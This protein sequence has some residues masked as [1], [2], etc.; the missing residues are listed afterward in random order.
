MV[1]TNRID[2]RQ[3]VLRLSLVVSMIL[4]AMPQFAAFGQDGSMGQPINLE[5][6]FNRASTDDLQSGSPR[7][8]FK[9]KALKKSELVVRNF[10]AE[11][12]TFYG[13][14]TLVALMTTQAEKNV[15][16]FRNDP[17]TLNTMV[18]VFLDPIGQVGFLGFLGASHATSSYFRSWHMLIGRAASEVAN[19]NGKHIPFNLRVANHIRSNKALSSAAAFLIKASPQIGL[20][21]GMMASDFIESYIRGFGADPSVKECA[22]GIREEF[23]KSYEKHYVQA[24]EVA[25]R[26]WVL[27]SHR[28]LDLV[29]DAISLIMG[30]MAN[31]LVIQKVITPGLK[32]AKDFV[33]PPVQG[34][35]AKV[36]LQRL[37]NVVG[38]SER[39]I[40][41]GVQI[42]FGA[43]GKIAS[44]SGNFMVRM[45]GLMVFMGL[46]GKVIEPFIIQK[47]WKSPRAIGRAKKARARFHAKTED[48]KRDKWTNPPGWDLIAREDTTR[49][50]FGVWGAMGIVKDYHLKKQTEAENV[51]HEL[52]IF[53]KR[54][55]EWRTHLMEKTY[56]GYYNWSSLVDQFLSS[57]IGSYQFYSD[58]LDK[59]FASIKDPKVKNPYTTYDPYHGVKGPI[60]ALSELTDQPVFDLKVAPDLPTAGESIA[61]DGSTRGA[62][63][64]KE[65]GPTSPE[66]LEISV[67]REMVI[68]TGHYIED[69]TGKSHFDEDTLKSL[70]SIKDD[71]LR[72]EEFQTEEYDRRAG[73]A[74][75]ELNDLSEKTMMKM[76]EVA[77]DPSDSNEKIQRLNELRQTVENLNQIRSQLGENPQPVVGGVSYLE[78]IQNHKVS[79]IDLPDAQI[80]VFPKWF[81]STYTAQPVDYLVATAVCGP[82]A[83]GWRKNQGEKPGFLEKSSLGLVRFV[84][85]RIVDFDFNL[86]GDHP[87]VAKNIKRA[88]WGISKTSDFLT[89]TQTLSNVLLGDEHR[90]DFKIYQKKYHTPDTGKDY[91]GLLDVLTSRLRVSLGDLYF[92]EKTHL[93]RQEFSRWWE[94]NVQPPIYDSLEIFHKEYAKLIQHELVPVFVNEDLDSSGEVPLG[95]FRSLV[96]ELSDWLGVVRN[97]FEIENQKV[98]DDKIRTE[99][100]K[101]FEKSAHALT[102]FFWSLKEQ[103]GKD[104]QQETNVG[105]DFQSLMGEISTLAMLSGIQ[106][107]AEVTSEDDMKKYD[108]S[109]KDFIVKTSLRSVV[110]LLNEAYNYYYMSTLVPDL[111]SDSTN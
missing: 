4:I 47:Y 49:M 36:G 5:T 69:L 79:G 39:P 73:L 42:V 1:K 97:I 24:C 67:Q 8:L 46:H 99:N 57:Y 84:P 38:R 48:L 31:H 106:R 25:Y 34:L 20:A 102:N 13:A 33:L 37:I 68:Q 27:I 17:M 58:I 107:P 32:S 7:T 93:Q 12:V 88:K 54:N 50:K 61:V 23:E 19:L 86:C 111:S 76:M 56:M 11:S 10:A 21:M 26:D 104:A 22:R 82:D 14:M 109:F 15:L 3:V 43:G 60:Q 64:D 30:S 90:D 40:W 35:S 72:L 110:G 6:I 51:L 103:V 52:E 77:M 65:E 55:E 94:E 101:K 2:L 59:S 66:V 62:L 81:K 63:K 87:L 85:P 78:L 89:G 83:E 9:S 45:G 44:R 29:P 98:D 41:K 75:R 105:S 92:D 53:K 71:F 96:T 95:I 100:I 16:G 74:I 108:P 80:K 18:N 91:V 70:S 28:I